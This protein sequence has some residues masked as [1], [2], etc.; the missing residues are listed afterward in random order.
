MSPSPSLRPLRLLSL[1]LLAALALAPTARAQTPLAQLAPGTW[2]QLRYRHIGPEGN[3]V[4]SV[5]GVPGD[6]TTYY[7]GAAAG[8]IWKTTD[9][10]AHWKPIFDA[11]DVQSVGALVVAPSDPNVVWAGTGEPFI[12]SHISIGNGVYRSTD[13][14]ATWQRMGL[15]ATGRIAR[16]VIDPANPDIVLVAAMGHSYGP[17]PERGVFRTTD[18]GRSWSKVLFVN[19]STG[20]SD[21]VMDPS[22]PRILYAATWQLEIHTWGRESGGAGS[23]IWKSTDGG[24]TWTRLEGHGLPDW[25]VGKIGLAISRANPDRVYAL[26]EAGDGVPWHGRPTKPGKLWRS[27]N[28]GR[29]W[30]MV[31]AD[32]ELGGRGAY[33]TRMAVSPDDPDEAYFLTSSF[34]KTLDGGA[35]TVDLPFRQQPGGDHHDIWIDPTNGDRMIVSHDGGVSITEN[36]GRTWQ[37]VTLPVAQMYHVTVDNRVPYWVFGNRQDGPSVMGPSNN[38]SAGF[39]GPPMIGRG[40]WRTVGG[41][42]SGWA[43]PDTVDDNIIWS[44]ASGFGSVS[45]IVTRYDRRTGQVHNVEIWPLASIGR[46]AKD[47]RYRFVW[48]FPLTISPHN[49]NRVY[50][51]SQYVHVTEDGG[52]TWREISP[53]LTRNDTTRMGVSGGLTPDNIG[54]E[55]AGVVFAIAESP[56]QEGVLWAGT[57]DGLVHVTQDGGRTW[58]DVTANLKGLPEWLTIS[59]IEPSHTEP[60]AAYVAIDGHQADNRDPWVYRTKD[61]G[62]S[63]KKIVDGIPPSPLSYAHIIREDP[64]RPGLLYLGTENA[65]YVSFDD[66]DHWQPLQSNLPHAPVYGMVVQP[67]YNDLVVGRYGRGFWILDDIT[68]IQQMT[69]EVAA[70]D[71]HVFRPR[72][73]W[74]LRTAEPAMAN[75]DDPN[76]GQDPPYG[77]P[78]NYW[79]K[80]AA[81]DSVTLRVADASG[82]TVRTMKG[83]AKAGINRV[84]WNLQTDPTH[85]ARMRTSPLYAPQ[86]RVGP[87]GWRPAPDIGRVSILAPPGTYTVT[88]VAGGQENSQSVEVRKD[89]E[90]GG[91]L[92]DIQAQ[93]AFMEKLTDDLNRAVD[94]VN[95]LELVRAQL[96]ELSRT[97]AADSTAAAAPDGGNADLRAAADSLQKKATRL[98]EKLAQ[99]KQ[100]GRG[101]DVIRWPMMLA[102]RLV[103]L[104]QQVGGSDY[105][106]TQPQRDAYQVLHD[107]LATHRAAYE[108]LLST[109]IPALNRKLRERGAGGVVPPGRGDRLDG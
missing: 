64:S 66:G 81:D 38:R 76:I 101:Q 65:L 33:Y 23:G 6:R 15:E 41:G 30:R 80:S 48:N 21:V 40:E 82:R 35:H 73:A 51:G 63:W 17:Q 3:R 106:P 31:S 95:G 53:D 12:R 34:T 52:R 94:I 109:D 43:T 68:P 74:R 54:V 56:V 16:I 26:I 4:S 70:S 84:W 13:A 79:L 85:E 71:V 7:A 107:E 93:T 69:P 100:T 8:G 1:T 57:N 42:E 104:A 24:E 60:G 2:A 58:T 20:A 87:K 96:Q 37:R 103:Y 108:H 88:L 19:D 102:G 39:F 72:P 25:P 78:L 28:G 22:N 32:R 92:A 36:R 105:R 18:G 89:P 90:S 62:R 91:T 83:P 97:L 14:G 5:A 50:V 99:L 49:H 45:G 55:Y 44:S 29:S 59:H 98:E 75:P 86:V 67:H 61:F 27:D 47:V 11:Q 46:P 9:G 77:T 10:G